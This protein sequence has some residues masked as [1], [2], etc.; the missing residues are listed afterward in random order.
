MV[1]QHI[2]WNHA[3][4]IYVEAGKRQTVNAFINGEQKDLWNQSINNE[5]GRLAQ[6]NNAGVR[7]ND[8]IDFIH[9]RDVPNDRN[10]TYANFVCN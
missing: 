3:N 4:H 2:L 6:G 9:H 1:A 8:Y 10:I 7:A 5:L